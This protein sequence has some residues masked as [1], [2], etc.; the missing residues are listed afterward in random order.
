MMSVQTILVFLI[1]ADMSWYWQFWQAVCIETFLHNTGHKV[2][3][4]TLVAFVAT[5]VRLSG[6]AFRQGR[7]GTDYQRQIYFT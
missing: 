1:S 7:L 3:V 4:V 5:W 2:V 6:N